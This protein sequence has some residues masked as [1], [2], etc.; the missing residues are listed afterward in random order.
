[1]R[2]PAKQ[3]FPLGSAL[4]FLQRAWRLN[5]A[6]ERLSSR[7]LREIGITA[8][9][10]LLLRCVGKYPGLIAGNLAEILHVDRG[11]VSAALKRLEKKA[12]IERRGDPR[13]QRRVTVGLTARGRAFDHPAERTV[14]GCIESLL[15][16]V[17]AAEIATTK[18][19]LDRLIAQL[20]RAAEATPER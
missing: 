11:T 14:E 18:R 10:R 1:M 13:D 9:Q 3:A 5:H 19:V 4:D 2:E 17:S 16:E 8:Q 20:E 7:M 6:L 12:L 15:A